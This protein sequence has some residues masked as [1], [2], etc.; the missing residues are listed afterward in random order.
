VLEHPGPG[1]KEVPLV[2]RH[3]LPRS[4]RATTPHLLAV[5]DGGDPEVYQR[6]EAIGRPL[7]VASVR[8][9]LGLD[10]PWTDVAIDHLPTRDELAAL[11]EDP[12]DEHCD[13]LLEAAYF[14]VGGE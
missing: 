9:S 12:G 14:D 7:P 8:V 2:Q 10:R 4:G 3:S 13:L 6:F 5:N 1:T 11:D